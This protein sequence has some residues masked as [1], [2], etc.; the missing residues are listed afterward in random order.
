MAQQGSGFDMSK[1]STATKIVGVSAIVYIIWTF[2]PFWYS[3]DLGPL[4]SSGINGFRFPMIISFLLA[5]VALVGVAFT[6]MGTQMKMQVKPGTVQLGIAVAALIF[7]LLGFVIKPGG[8]FLSSVIGFSWGL[9]VGVV[10]AVVWTY[11]AWMWHSE[12]GASAP[13]PPAG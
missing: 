13:P 9:F 7:T 5:L 2:L 10:I 6:A 8:G 11:G 4:G 12:P 1:M 3:V